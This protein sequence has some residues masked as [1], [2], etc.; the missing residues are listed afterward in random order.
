MQFAGKVAIVTGAGSGVGRDTA[1]LYAA[2]GASVLAAD[3]DGQR[4][5]E[6]VRAIE[7]AGGQAAFARVDLS[8]RAQAHAMVDAAVARFGRLDILANV[9]GI[10][11]SMSVED[12][13]E[14]HWAR[15]LAVDLTGPFFACQAALRRMKEG[16]GGVIVNV[17]SG[18]AFYPIAGKAAYS[19]AKGGLVSLS[20]VVALEGA[21]YGVRVNIVVPGN[22]A[23]DT[24]LA[25]FGGPPPG[26][27]GPLMER[28]IEP[29]E[30][31]EV[32]VWCS[33]DAAGAVNGAILRVDAGKYML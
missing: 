18:A 21:P 29:R 5:Q 27:G 31:A 2:E 7:K 22:T 10:Y 1:L 20:R 25:N 16:R 12:V 8:E 23:S 4:G 17:A 14:E 24:V 15:M 28:W 30:I 19:A 33:S 13:T 9:A 11:P 32:I 3:I 26:R 6:T